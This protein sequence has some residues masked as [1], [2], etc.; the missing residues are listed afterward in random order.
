[1]KLYPRPW[2]LVFQSLYQIPT[3]HSFT[4]TLN[5]HLF[6]LLLLVSLAF[7]LF[8]LFFSP[9]SYGDAIFHVSVFI[10]YENPIQNY[11]RRYNFYSTLFCPLFLLFKPCFPPL[12]FFFGLF[13]SIF[14]VVLTFCLISRFCFPIFD[15]FQNYPYRN[16]APFFFVC[17]YASDRV[18]SEF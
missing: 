7:H 8:S 4:L 15:S 13:I 1:M 6:P 10:L 3:V 16:L 14:S 5:L 12:F 2:P 18:D 9:N 17:V 11:L